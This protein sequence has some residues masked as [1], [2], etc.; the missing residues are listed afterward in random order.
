MT[1]TTNKNCM[2]IHVKDYRRNKYEE[3]K[4]YYRMLKLDQIVKKT[5]ITF[6]FSLIL[7]VY[8]L[9]LGFITKM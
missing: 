3:D 4:K 1:R 5:I 9:V 7:V 6:G 8:L 2:T